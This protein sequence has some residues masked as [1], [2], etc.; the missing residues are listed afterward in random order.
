MTITLHKTVAERGIELRDK[1]GGEL[2]FTITPP[3]FQPGASRHKWQIEYKREGK[4]LVHRCW[5]S[6]EAAEF[7][8]LAIYAEAKN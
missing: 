8:C 7:A 3:T 6:L 4:M 1:D 2:W 5:Y